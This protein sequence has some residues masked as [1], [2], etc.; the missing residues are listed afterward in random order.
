LPLLVVF[1]FCIC[2]VIIS[3]FWYQNSHFCL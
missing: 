2:Y 1:S 3:L